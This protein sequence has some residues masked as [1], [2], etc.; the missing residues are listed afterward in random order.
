MEAEPNG[1]YLGFACHGCKEMIEII[2]DDASDECRFVAD[3]V[4]QIL[5]RGCGHRGHYKMQAV[6][7]VPGRAPSNG[8][9]P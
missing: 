9:A 3:D 1:F 6:E 8:S 7:R 2:I 4:L 5:C